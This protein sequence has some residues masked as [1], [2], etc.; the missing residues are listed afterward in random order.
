MEN[1]GFS[2]KKWK[3]LSF[4][5]IIVIGSGILVPSAFAASPTLNDIM[6]KLLGLDTKVTAIKAKTDN[7]PADRQASRAS[8]PRWTN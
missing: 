5:L 2:Q 7:L 3:Y 6:S 1:S 4:G 8:K